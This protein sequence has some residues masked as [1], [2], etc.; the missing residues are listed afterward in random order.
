MTSRVFAL[1]AM[2]V[3]CVL[4][5]GALETA[6]VCRTPLEGQSNVSV[7]MAT[8]EKTAQVRQG[9]EMISIKIMSFANLSNLRSNYGWVKN[10]LC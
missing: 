9:N 2:S 7:T 3:K 8:R 10:R 5:V 6:P 4:C 1:M